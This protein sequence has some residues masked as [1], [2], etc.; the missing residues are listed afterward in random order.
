MSATRLL[1]LGVIRTLQP[2]HGYE[3]RREL[4]SWRVEATTNLKPGSIYG[5]LPW[6]A[7]A[8]CSRE[9]RDPDVLIGAG[10]AV[11]LAA[12]LAVWGARVFQRQSA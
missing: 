6:T 7:P 2:I 9:L 5:L 11:A 4:I 12:L 3:V 10:I 1:V 8:A